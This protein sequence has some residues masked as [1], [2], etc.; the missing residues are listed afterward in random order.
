MGPSAAVQLAN[1]HHPNFSRYRTFHW[2]MLRHAETLR[3]RA[4]D[5]LFSE[6]HNNKLNTFMGLKPPEGIPT[7][8]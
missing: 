8:T 1:R 3:H 5:P 4:L 2:L 7:L 6:Q